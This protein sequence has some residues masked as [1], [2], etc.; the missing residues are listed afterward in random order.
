MII[1]NPEPYCSLYEFINSKIIPKYP[2]LTKCYQDNFDEEGN[3]R[4]QYYIRYAANLSLNEWDDLFFNILADI[5]EYLGI[6]GI[7]MDEDFAVDFI[8]TIDGD[9][10]E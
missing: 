5:E 8:L 6:C 7:S 10:H 9:F 1:R 3:P 2:C 4:V